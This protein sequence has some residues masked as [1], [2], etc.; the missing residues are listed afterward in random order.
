MKIRIHVA[1]SFDV[2]CSGANEPKVH[3]GSRMFL[4]AAD[5]GFPRDIGR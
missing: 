3:D 5:A 1:S 2:L 4:A